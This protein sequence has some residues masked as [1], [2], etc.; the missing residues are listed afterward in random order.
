[1]EFEWTLDSPESSHSLEPG[2]KSAVTVPQFLSPN[3]QRKCLLFSHDDHEAAAPRHRRVQQVPLKQQEML[4]GH[5][6]DHGRK[7][8]SL[9]FM[10]R[11]GVRGSQFIQFTK[12][13]HH[14]PF[15]KFHH[16]G[17]ILLGYLSHKTDVAIEHF[18]VV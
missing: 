14:F 16:Y 7:L 15:F 9:G 2:K 13:I 10:N 17:T 11:D 18:L 5:G 12:F 4:H 8:R 3:P 1:S 6:N